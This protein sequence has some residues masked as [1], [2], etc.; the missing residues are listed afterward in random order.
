MVLDV[1]V[2]RVDRASRPEARRRRVDGAFGRRAARA[3]RGWYRGLR[4]RLDRLSPGRATWVARPT[5]L[6][7]SISDPDRVARILGRCPASASRP[8]PR[9]R[10]KMRSGRSAPRTRRSRV[11]SRRRA[12]GARRGRPTNPP[13]RRRQRFVRAPRAGR[14]RPMRP[15][16]DA[17]RRRRA[18]GARGA[19]SRADRLGAPR[20][21]ASR[22]L[23]PLG[24]RARSRRHRRGGRRGGTSARRDRP[25]RAVAACC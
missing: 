6:D 23:R 22:R 2:G 14:G 18:R 15:A 24:R 11:R 12:P 16:E 20:A 1:R 21:R 13:E 7:G 4:Y 19:A 3:P 8:G 5:R 9:P 10:V 25:A 17:A